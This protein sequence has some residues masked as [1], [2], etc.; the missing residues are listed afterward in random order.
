MPWT[1]QRHRES[2]KWGEEVLKEWFALNVYDNGQLVCAVHFDEFPSEEQIEKAI[3]E[4]A[5]C[6]GVGEIVKRYSPH[7]PF[8]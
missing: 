3:L 2:R 7:V 5:G 6:E 8:A 1:A 4:N